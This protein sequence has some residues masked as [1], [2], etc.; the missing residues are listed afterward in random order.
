M[1]RKVNLFIVGAMKAGTTSF[2]DLLSQSEEIYIP[3]IKEPH[4]FVK[5]LPKSIY[6]PSRYFNLDHYFERDF[7]KPLHIAKLDEPEHYQKLYTKVQSKHNYL[8]D[9]ST[10]YLNSPES[11]Q[12]IFKYNPEAKIIILIRD[13]LKRAFSHFNM[14]LGLGRTLKTFDAEISDQLEHYRKGSLSPWSYLNMSLYSNQ[15]TRYLELF[16]NNVLVLNFEDLV[17]NDVKVFRQLGLF[18]ELSFKNPKILK[19][20][21]TRQLQYPKINRWLIQTG[22]KDIFS[23]VIPSTIKQKLFRHISSSTKP[24]ID[25]SKN[26]EQQLSEVFKKDQAK[27]HQL[28]T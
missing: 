10:C 2:V 21:T 12:K 22:V 24:K 27:L 5:H 1:S 13:P 6:T 17:K 8:V 18:L 23:L 9:A 7:P 4:Y 15:V 3:P 26:T 11:A 28:L 25:L 19:Q 16:G 14:D 20:N